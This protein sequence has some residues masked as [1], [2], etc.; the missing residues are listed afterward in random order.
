[1]VFFHVFP[2][3]CPAH[4]LIIGL[5]VL[6]RVRISSSLLSG[7]RDNSDAVLEGKIVLFGTLEPLMSDA[8]LQ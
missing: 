4:K 6:I 1:M 7:R 8:K 3:L 5:E 2:V